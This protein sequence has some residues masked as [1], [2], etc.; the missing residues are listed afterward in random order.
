MKMNLKYLIHSCLKMC[1]TLRYN[2][3]NYCYKN[4]CVYVKESFIK[5]CSE[6]T[7]TY[8]LL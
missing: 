7:R 6:T 1:N 2:K 3:L 5:T 8:K 4:K